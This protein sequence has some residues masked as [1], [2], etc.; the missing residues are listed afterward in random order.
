L[1]VA[2]GIFAADMQVRL[3]NDGPVTITLDSGA[4]AAL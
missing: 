4:P 1:T 3:L 2:E